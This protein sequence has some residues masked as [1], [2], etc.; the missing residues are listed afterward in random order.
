MENNQLS[1]A[2]T[3]SR[4]L[5]GDY[6]IRLL[7]GTSVSGEY[8]GAISAVEDSRV[9]FTIDKSQGSRSGD[10]TIVNLDIPAG[11]TIFTAMTDIT[12]VG[13]VIAYLK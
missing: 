4:M 2:D 1:T 9:S 8:F 13:K 12:V 10:D 7:T 6:G 11:F 5:N 3:K